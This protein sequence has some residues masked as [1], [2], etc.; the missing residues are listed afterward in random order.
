MEEANSL[1]T[2]IAIMTKG[3]IRCI[4]SVQHLK[5]KYGAGYVLEIKWTSTQEN[6]EL[7]KQMISNIFSEW[8]VREESTNRLCADV[9]QKSVT[10]LS[11][12]FQA[13]EDMK[14]NS[15]LNVS[16]YSFSQTTLEQVFIYFA[17]QHNI[18]EV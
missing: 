11:S 5:D 13:L 8:K 7:V 12:I 3:I 15:I 9:P 6:A 18:I 17:N 4:G 1:C 10:S 2:R 16:E 14:N